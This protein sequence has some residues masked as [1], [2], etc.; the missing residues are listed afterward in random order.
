MKN[1]KYLV[2]VLVLLSLGKNT[3]AQIEPMYGMYRFNALAINPA[4]AGANRST[5]ISLLSRWQW[6]AIEGA[7]KT[8]VASLNLPFRQNVGFG[9]NLVSDNIGPVSDFYIGTDYAYQIPITRKTKI[10]AGLRLS[11][12]NHRVD[13]N[14]R[15]LI[16]EA[17]E[18][19]KFNMNSG[20][21]VNPGLGFL[22]INPKFYIGYSMPRLLKFYYGSLYDV[23]SYKDVQHSFLY[24]GYNYRYNREITFRPSFIMNTSLDAPVS[25]D[26]NAMATFKDVL[27]LGLMYRAKDAVGLVMGYKFNNGLYAGYSYEYPISDIRRV[28]RMTHEFALR[29]AIK[30][31][32]NQ[33][34]LTPRYFN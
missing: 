20:F 25:F 34:I 1:S 8:H 33:R 32:S 19:F 11:I 12:I 28:S 29:F 4:Q 7:P 3:Q 13:L 31:V 18:S 21:R 10:S 24:A 14:S 2:V 16:D 17:D 6:T 9:L 26:I 22:V 27:D 15:R 5:D 23:S 30:D